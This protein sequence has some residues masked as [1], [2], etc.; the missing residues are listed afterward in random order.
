MDALLTRQYGLLAC[1]DGPAI[2]KTG[3]TMGERG[4]VKDGGAKGRG[5]GA[6]GSR[7]ITGEMTQGQGGRG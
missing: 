3:L 1:L 2:A 6:E 7:L 4:R 5:Q